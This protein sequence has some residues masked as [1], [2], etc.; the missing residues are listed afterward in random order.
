M[1]ITLTMIQN[2]IDVASCMGLN[3]GQNFM[4]SPENG[5]RC[6]PQAKKNTA[7]LNH[8]PRTKSDQGHLL[9]KWKLSWIEGRGQNQNHP[10]WTNQ[11]RTEAHPEPKHTKDQRAEHRKT[12]GKERR[13]FLHRIIY[14]LNH[15]IHRKP[16]NKSWQKLRP[17]LLN[18]ECSLLR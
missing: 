9:N 5:Q 6:V 16:Q 17:T 3:T 15:I 7:G 18:V 13:T 12:L 8:R 2:Y 11:I 14:E 1:L 10:I 4:S